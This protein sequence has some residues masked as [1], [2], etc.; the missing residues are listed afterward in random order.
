MAGA[1]FVWHGE[2]AKNVTRE[3]A[4]RRVRDCCLLLQR[5]VQLSMKLGGRTRS[6]MLAKNE[7]GQR[8]D[9]LTGDKP[10]RINTYRSKPGEVPRVQT[11]RLRAGYMVEMD[12]QGLPVGRMGTNVI[13]ARA[14]E[15][16]FLERNLQPRPHVRPAIAS[17]ESQ[18]RMIFE[19][20]FNLPNT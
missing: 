3:E 18:M 6:G 7:K 1:R 2:M 12:D 4:V 11:G 8:V 9:P 20:P 5:A 19:T 16:G 13:Y 14:I 17:C 10:E 15:L